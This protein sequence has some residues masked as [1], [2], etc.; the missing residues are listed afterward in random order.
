[1]SD[2]AESIEAKALAA[3]D[4]INRGDLEGF[5]AQIHPEVEFHSL[6]AEAEGT[7][8]RGH[9]GVREWWNTVAGSF[10]D[11]QFH[12]EEIVD[13]G[14]RG[15]A[16]LLVTGTMAGVVVPQRMWQAFIMRDGKPAWWQTFRSEAEARA[17]I[18]RD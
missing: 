4:A 16:K 9:E 17:A 14:G 12:A 2:P 3:Y 10:G 1:M 11:M 18:E 7:V 6:V 8:Y 5:V 13:L 15:F